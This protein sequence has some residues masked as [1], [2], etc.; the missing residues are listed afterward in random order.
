MSVSAETIEKIQS[1]RKQLEHHS[2]LYYVQDAPEITDLEYDVLMRQLQQIEAE[3]PELLT[4]DSPSQRVGGAAIEGFVKVVHRSPLLSLDNAFS[5][6]ELSAFDDR[7]KKV[8]DLPA[9]AKPEYMAELKI[10]G[11]TIALTYENGILVRAATRGDGT[12]GEDVTLNVKTIGSIPLAL[13]GGEGVNLGV[14]GEVYLPKSAFERLNAKRREAGESLF[15]NPRN[16]AAGS[17]RQ[18][19]PKITATRPLSAFIYDILYIEGCERP[20]TQAAGFDLLRD[21][22]FKTN[23]ESKKCVGIGEVIEFCDYWTQHREELDYVIDGIVIKLNPIADQ[24]SL[25]N[26]AKAPRAKIAFKFPAQ[27]VETKITDIEIGVGRTGVLTP[28][29][30]LD[31][32]NVAGSTISRATLHNEDNIY[33][34]DIRIGDTVIIQKAGDVIPEVVRSL[35]EKRDGNEQIFKM[36]EKCPECGSQV[37]REPGE[38]AMRC[39][40]S[41]CP[42]QLRE[43]I[44]HFVSRDAMNIDGL[45]EAVVIQLIDA[46][47]VHDVSDLYR[48]EAAKLLN[49]ERFAEKSA[50]NLVQA[51]EASK[52]NQLSRLMFALGIRHV[53]AGA[54]RDLTR[55]YRSL[56]EIMNLTLEELTA[57]DSIGPKIANSIVHYFAEPHNRELISKL[58]ALGINMTERESEGSSQRLLGQ[59]LVVT[60]TLPTFG[61]SEIEELIRR[62]GGKA[63]SSVSK[64]TS[65][66][67]AGENAGSKLEKAQSLGIAVLTEAEFLELL[68]REN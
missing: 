48:L 54:A 26:T 45:G 27:Q 24:E 60:G 30:V 29:A 15:A 36:P 7:V 25:G 6:E 68:N 62:N 17:L 41:T 46:G 53:G 58:Q 67:I 55:Y 1:L 35:P 65:Y 43:G 22:R 33:A 8:L 38:A 42:A 50:A 63:A 61:R 31:P 9:D 11:L 66:V 3:Y 13:N 34:K 37:Y 32:V 49:L 2:Y 19:D 39:L 56:D 12:V 44:I 64:N 5:A 40:G 47:L 18:L 14:R 23:P 4:P 28:V 52:S 10:D 21:F 51:I 20:T 16:I 57:I 59:T